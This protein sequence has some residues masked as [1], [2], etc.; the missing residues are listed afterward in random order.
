MMNSMTMNTTG[1][2]MI[3]RDIFIAKYRASLITGLL[4][5]A[6]PLWAGAEEPSQSEALEVIELP[7]EQLETSS[8]SVNWGCDVLLIQDSRR[9]RAG[10]CPG[11][12]PE[13][14]VT[15]LEIE[16]DEEPAE[17]LPQRRS[18]LLY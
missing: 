6:L 17:S 14:E 18:K 5:A 2:S 16:S 13:A 9:F 1:H 11:D 15:E 7:S 10:H 12:E 3:C 4:A 8:L